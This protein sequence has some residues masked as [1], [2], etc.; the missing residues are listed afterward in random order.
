M[1]NK[2]M[3][4]LGLVAIFLIVI[5]SIMRRSPAIVDRKPPLPI[6]Q[7]TSGA[8]ANGMDVSSRVN[9][10]QDTTGGSSYA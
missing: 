8:I 6:N 3:I 1:M 2:D 9:F 7:Y 10:Q 5:F 4:C